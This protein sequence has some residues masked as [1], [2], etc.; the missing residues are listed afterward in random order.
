[1]NTLKVFYLFIYLFHHFLIDYI[2]KFGV[3][4]LE[5]LVSYHQSEFKGR[6]FT[7][8]LKAEDYH[9]EYHVIFYKHE[10]STNTKIYKV[11]Y[12]QLT[13]VVKLQAVGSKQWNNTWQVWV[14]AY[15]QFLR[16]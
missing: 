10:N 13:K 9:P 2:E 15:F 11:L 5:S 1:M 6:W 7:F 4:F 8:T 12:T 16:V 3:F 14:P